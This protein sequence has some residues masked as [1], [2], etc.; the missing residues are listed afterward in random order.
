MENIY[1]TDTSS[2]QQKSNT[3]VKYELLAELII[4]RAEYP[5]AT[6]LVPFKPLSSLLAVLAC[7]LHTV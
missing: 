4:P 6:C 2:Q 1:I 3:A 5:C 7:M